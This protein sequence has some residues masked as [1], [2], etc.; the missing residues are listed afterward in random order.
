MQI[1]QSSWTLKDGWVA[2]KSSNLK[3]KANFVIVFGAI[4][5][6]NNEDRFYEIK[7]NYPNAN[8]LL[9]S[10]AGEIIKDRVEDNSII[11]TAI[12]YE[13]TK[14]NFVE[15]N[16]E[17]F[18]NSYSCGAEI[19]AQMDFKNLKH[20]LVLSDGILVNGDQ[21]VRA[22]NKNFPDDVVVTGG[23]AADNG[24]FSKTYVGLNS[25]P[26]SGTI[27]AVGHYG[28]QIS[29]S[30]GSKGGWDE[31]GPTRTVTKS[32]KNV[33]YELDG[34]N[35]L[36]LYKNYLGEKADELPGSALLFPLCVYGDSGDHIVRTILSIDEERGSMIFAGDIPQDSTVRFMMANFERLIDGA[37][38]AAKESLTKFENCKPTL[39]LMISCIGRK[40]VLGPRIDEEVEAVNEIFGSE[41]VYAGFYSNGE[42]SPIVDSTKCSLHNQT[43]TI[44]TYTEM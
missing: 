27:V 20:V 29:I 30:H 11:V 38:D 35:A 8:I 34:K 25:P 15:I 12:Y 21:L 4:D 14:L 22:M 31:F 23:L 24:R 9:C 6:I 28:D 5:I 19:A 16:V 17:D 26:T 40:L 37:C 18:E 44:T 1:E 13:K 39:V 10:T 3:E 32:D 42:I 33:L 7:E 41:A 36:E 43:M 2:T